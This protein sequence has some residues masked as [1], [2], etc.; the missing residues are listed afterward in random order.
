MLIVDD[1]QEAPVSE[2]IYKYPPLTHV[3][4]I[5]SAV[6]VAAELVMAMERQYAGDARVVPGMSVKVLPKSVE[7]RMLMVIY[8]L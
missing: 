3:T 4:W 8:K 6:W 2:E 7:R 1:D 5:A